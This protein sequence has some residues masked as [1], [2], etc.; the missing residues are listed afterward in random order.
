MGIELSYA[1]GVTAAEPWPV[2]T[3]KAVYAVL[4]VVVAGL[5]MTLVAAMIAVLVHSED[6]IL[7]FSPLAGVC[8]SIVGIFAGTQM[9]R[10]KRWHWAGIMVGSVVMVA[11]AAVELWCYHLAQVTPVHG[12]FDAMIR[13]MFMMYF[14]LWI[15]WGVIAL[16]AGICGRV[17]DRATAAHSFL[18]R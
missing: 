12:P 14:L 18:G 6:A 8:G 16:S 7:V 13:G 15:G 11:G 5:G 10:A 1:G 4:V 3:V 2:R 9:R 17:W